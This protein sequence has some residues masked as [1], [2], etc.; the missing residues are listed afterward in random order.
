MLCYFTKQRRKDST[1]LKEHKQETDS[2]RPICSASIFKST[3]F[4]SAKECINLNRRIASDD[5]AKILPPKRSN[6]VDKLYL[7]KNAFCL[8]GEVAMVIDFKQCCT[9]KGQRFCY[10]NENQFRTY[11]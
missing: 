1:K 8:V 7:L 10:L 2:S 4:N 5:L 6:N 9:A 11:S 3:E